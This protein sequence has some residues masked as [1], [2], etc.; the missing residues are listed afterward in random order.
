MNRII[1]HIRRHVLRG[2]IAIIPLALSALAVYFLYILIDRRVTTVI[3]RM[4]HRNIPGLGILLLV[5]MLYILGLL[6]TAL[7]GRE[8]LRLIEK[9]L[10]RIP[11]IRTTYQVGKQISSALSPTHRQVFTRAVMVEFLRPGM[12]TIGF[13]TGILEP[14]TGGERIL[15][16]FIP[17]PPNPTTGQMILVRESDVRDTGWTVD[18]AMRTMISAGIIG[19]SHIR[20]WTDEPAPGLARPPADCRDALPRG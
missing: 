12:W 13:V 16:V 4:I 15:K 5:I 8:F 7:T 1:H 18:E 14:T 3:A 2:A 20:P 6:A 9:A 10:D 11:L 19:P 17:S